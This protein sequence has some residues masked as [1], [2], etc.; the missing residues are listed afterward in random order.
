MTGLA[1]IENNGNSRALVLSRS[2]QKEEGNGFRIL[3]QFALYNGKVV[4]L[5]INLNLIILLN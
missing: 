5:F 3:L 4:R 2:K 1:V